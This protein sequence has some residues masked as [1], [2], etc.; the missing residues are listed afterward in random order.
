MNDEIYRTADFPTICSLYHLHFQPEQFERDPRSPGKVAV[1]FKRNES[2]DET[3]R[4][5]RSR[6]LAVEPIAFLETT[7]EVR[8]R[9]RDCA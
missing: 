8:G 3:L 1:C 6:E 5:L 4:S 2:L 9:L 7:R